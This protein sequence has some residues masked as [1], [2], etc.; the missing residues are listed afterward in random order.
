MF[1]TEGHFEETLHEQP[2]ED[3]I[4]NHIA[5]TVE[6]LEIREIRVHLTMVGRVSDRSNRFHLYEHHNTIPYS[7]F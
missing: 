3:T 4:G 7:T 1:L 5:L 6:N 2:S